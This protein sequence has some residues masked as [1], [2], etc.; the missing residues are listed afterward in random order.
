A[1]DVRDQEDEEDHR[2]LD[3]LTFAVRLE[4]GTDQQQGS[5][6]RA[7][8]RGESGPEPE[9]RGVRQGRRLQIALEKDA[10]G[11]RVQPGQQDDEGDVLLRRTGQR[12]GL[13]DQIEPCDGYPQGNGDDE[14]VTVG[15]PPARDGQ[16]TDRNGE[17]H[18]DERNDRVHRRRGHASASL[19]VADRASGWDMDIVYP[20][21]A[22][23]S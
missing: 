9:E 23:P 5:A 7:D 3:P 2:V 21:A 22:P 16:R 19:T 17:E 15:L 10:P 18:R 14:L 1:A 8:E 11:N 13:A 20:G 12:R 6:R 4:E